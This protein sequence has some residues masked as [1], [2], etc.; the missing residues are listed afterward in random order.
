MRASGDSGS[1]VLGWL[2][3]LV[4]V[5]AVLGLLAFDGIA[6]AKTSF[7]AADHATSAAKAAAD[8]YRSSRNAQAA[9]DA[10]VAEIPAGSETIDPASFS[11]DPTDGAVTLEVRAQATTVWMQYVGPLKKY[12][13]VTQTGEGSPTP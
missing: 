8:T 10:A 1:I 13:Y 11:V 9:Y 2:T 12:R 6:L 3:R 5:V 7:T 4:A